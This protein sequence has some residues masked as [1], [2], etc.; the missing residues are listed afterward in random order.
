MISPFYIILLLLVVV[1]TL[2]TLRTR[3]KFISSNLPPANVGYIP[4]AGVGLNFAKDPLQ[5]VTQQYK[6][7]G[8]IFTLNL[9]GKRCTFLVGPDAHEPFFGKGDKELSQEEP[10][11]F[12]VPIFG[13]EV[14]YDAPLHIR[15]QQ[16]KFIRKSLSTEALKTYVD[17]IVYETEQYFSKAWGN[18]GVSDIRKDLSELIILT[19]SNCLMGKE[20]RETLFKEV[21]HLFQLLDEGL[22]PISVFWPYLP[23]PQHRKRDQAREEMVK[24]YTKII[25]ARKANPEEKH[26]DVLQ[27]FM[28][29]KYRDGRSLSER[30]I[31]GMMIALLFAGQ[32]TSSVTSTWT[33]LYLLKHKEFLGPVLE[34]QKELLASSNGQLTYDVISQ[35]HRLKNCIKEALRLHPP[36]IFVMRAVEEP[37]NYKNYY[38]PKGDTIFV[39]PALSMRLPEVFKN[40]NTYDPDRFSKGREEDLKFKYGFLGFGGGR[41]GCMG[42]QFAYL[43]IK[44]IWSVLLRNFDME[45]IGDIPE[46]NYKAMVVGPKACAIRYKRKKV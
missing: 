33:G 8:E 24:I 29:A 32:H 19:A 6:R 31:T 44:T 43:Q 1:V 17:K 5:F 38:I 16:L 46:P 35:M 25:K 13:K 21:A 23:I 36:L 41:H 15:T 3:R 2:F 42:E 30:E 11:R 40:P 28:D 37:F 22:T 4:V 26:D 14:V 34:E 7:Y 10:Y 9:F 27:V 18:E 20:I 39:S 45:V 12:C